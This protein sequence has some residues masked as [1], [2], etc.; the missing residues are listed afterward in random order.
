MSE[1][2]TI[3]ALSSGAGVSAVAI[4]RIS[5]PRAGWV[6]DR[7]TKGA[8]PEP[9]R[10]SVRR[11]ISYESGD[12]L[13]VA[14]VLWMPGPGSFT[15]EDCAELHVHGSQA[16][17]AAVLRELHRLDAVRMAS[18]GEF[19]RRAYAN[20]KLDLVEVEGLGDLLAAATD[21]QRQQAIRQMSGRASSVFEDWRG[22]L[23]QIR[24]LIEAAVDFVDQHGV[25][26]EAATV[27]DAEIGDLAAQIRQAVLESSRAELV[28]SGVRVALV[29]HP[30]TGKSSLL[31]AMARREAALVSPVAGTTRDVISVTLDLD[32]LPV[33]VNDTAGLK[34]QSPDVVEAAG[35]AKAREEAGLSD[36]VFWV[37][38]PDVVSSDKVEDGIDP[39]L[40]VCGKCDLAQ[41]EPILARNDHLGCPVIHVS[42]RSGQGLPDLVSRLA[43][44]AKAMVGQTGDAVASNSRQREVLVDVLD[45]L[46]KAGGVG[47]SSPELKAELIRAATESLGRITGRSDVEEWLGSIFSRFCVGK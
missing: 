40:I 23:I 1:T 27:V 31:N 2:D 4:V 39:D 44:M 12:I 43:G 15:G 41:Q 19:T 10:L 47:P 11:I 32:G 29:G 22:R 20:G 6:V 33:I 3:Y 25:A 17:I 24:A 16:V 45:A 34:D 28:R 7:L 35:I 26:E 21:G 42:A 38:S 36:I 9:R 14:G 30:N 46:D 8:R 13:D 5:G 37:C 18:A